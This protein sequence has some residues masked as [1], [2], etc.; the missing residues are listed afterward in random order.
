MSTKEKVISVFL[1]DFFSSSYK[2]LIPIFADSDFLLCLNAK[3]YFHNK[4]ND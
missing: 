2:L 1:S 4:M 3:Y